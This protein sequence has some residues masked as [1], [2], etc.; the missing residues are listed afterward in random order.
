[1]DSYYNIKQGEGAAGGAE[2]SPA[3]RRPFTT[4]SGHQF[5]VLDDQTLVPFLPAQHFDRDLLEFRQFRKRG[6]V[7]AFA[8]HL[9]FAVFRVVEH[10]PHDQTR[11]QCQ[12][13][14][15]DDEQP[16]P[17]GAL[18]A[19]R[20]AA[21]PTLQSA[22]LSVCCCSR[23]RHSYCFLGFIGTLPVRRLFGWRDC[24]IELFMCAYFETHQ[25]PG[26]SKTAHCS[27]AVIFQQLVRDTK[28]RTSNQKHSLRFRAP[29]LSLGC[30]TGLR[31]S[32]PDAGDSNKPNLLRLQSRSFE[33]KVFLT[34]PDSKPS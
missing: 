19:G 24:E 11:L 21:A 9:H 25:K 14:P 30:W 31:Q 2:R 23:L 28:S 10:F 16:S 27:R 7:Y 6:Y 17:T 26:K 8:L 15:R 33:N 12:F 5:S 20:P 34:I 4:Y 1:M 18:V 22:K 32:T 29:W 13:V 3:R